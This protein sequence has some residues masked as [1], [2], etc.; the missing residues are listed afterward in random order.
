MAKTTEKKSQARDEWKDVVGCL[1]CGLPLEKESRKVATEIGDVCPHCV[2]KR[3]HLKTYDEVFDR[4]VDDYFVKE[5]RMSRDEA[6]KAA[7][8]HLKKVPAWKEG[9]TIVELAS[10]AGTFNT[11]LTAAKAAGLV[12][13]LNGK[14]PLTMFAPTDE[15]FAKLPKGTVEGLLKDKN[16]LKSVLTYHVS[17]GRLYAEDVV[18]RKSIKTVQGGSISV[19]TS[20]G[21]MLDNA[22]VIKTDLEATDGVVHIIDNVLIPK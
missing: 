5:K 14:G 10:S 8:A 7:R 19:D 1:S 12:D 21:V 11:L 18:K 20:K 3:G 15:A 4:L 22:N 2:D 9:K 16:R 17:A 13:T 6:E